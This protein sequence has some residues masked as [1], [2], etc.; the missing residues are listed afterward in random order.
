MLTRSRNPKHQLARPHAITSRQPARQRQ[1]RPAQ[2]P[3]HART[4]LTGR[5]QVPQTRRQRT[6]PRRHVLL[7]ETDTTT[8]RHF[9]TVHPQ[10]HH[11]AEC[12]NPQAPATSGTTAPGDLSATAQ[13]EPASQ[14][15]HAPP[16]GPAVRPTEPLSPGRQA[17]DLDPGPDPACTT[18]PEDAPRSADPGSRRGPPPVSEGHAREAERPADNAATPPAP[19]NPTTTRGARSGRGGHAKTPTRHSNT[20]TSGRT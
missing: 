20:T 1:H 5:R 13:A 12:P 8:A 14:R 17:P 6:P 3:T 9:D 4:H 19:P 15:H 10:A 7:P 11:P 2:S 16:A 18:V